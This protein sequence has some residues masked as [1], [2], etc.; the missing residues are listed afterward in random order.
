MKTYRK[1]LLGTFACV[2][3][4]LPLGTSVAVSGSA[5]DCSCVTAIAPGLTKIGTLASVKGSVLVRGTSGFG[6]AKDGAP[7]TPGAQVL[8]GAQSSAVVNAGQ[9][10]LPA[11]ANSTVE[12]SAKGQKAC[13][14]LTRT[15][16]EAIEQSAALGGTGAAA[17]AGAGAAAGA[18]T[19][20]MLVVGA[21]TLGL[22]ATGLATAV[23]NSNK[24][25]D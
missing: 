17:G 4:T 7:L 15:F 6:E 1:A 23:V 22:A 24:A 21:G 11:P 12:I 16:E 9:C 13:I 19:T 18:S 8:I 3:G 20:T 5:D 25:S 14:E 2:L 10:S